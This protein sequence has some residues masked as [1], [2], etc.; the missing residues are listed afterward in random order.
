MLPLEAY[1]FLL[2]VTLA[3]LIA[4]MHDLFAAAMLFGIFSWQFF[5]FIRG[6]PTP[7]P[8]RRARSVPSWPPPVP[9]PASLSWRAPWPISPLPRSGTS[10]WG[11]K[12]PI[13]P[14]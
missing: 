13:Q 5:P 10:C 3:M 12:W 14:A 7:T 2:L 11:L 8:T 6:S 4:R 1:L 9:R